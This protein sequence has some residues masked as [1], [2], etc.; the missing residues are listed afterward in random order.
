MSYK[1]YLADLLLAANARSFGI[2]DEGEFDG[3]LNIVSFTIPDSI[4]PNDRIE[5]H[6][7]VD[8][9]DVVD[10]GRFPGGK[11]TVTNALL[12]V[13]EGV[14]VLVDADQ[15]P[16]PIRYSIHFEVVHRRPVDEKDLFAELQRRARRGAAEA[17]A[18]SN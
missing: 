3:S 17:I 9:E 16:G 12:T 11:V 5:L 14:A 8:E 10:V 15:P 7:D 18:A 13:N 4:Q 2:E 1:A 6:L